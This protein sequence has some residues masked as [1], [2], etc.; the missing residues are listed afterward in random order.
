M[1]LQVKTP[2]R[3][4]GFLPFQWKFLLNANQFPKI[5]L[6]SSQLRMPPEADVQ[7]SAS[8]THGSPALDDADNLIPARCKEGDMRFTAA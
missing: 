8:E 6:A 7:L 3:E 2:A 5:L 1:E 4:L